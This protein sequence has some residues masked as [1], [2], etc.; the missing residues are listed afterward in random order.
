[1]SELVA[2]LRTL[3]ADA[4]DLRAAADRI[5][6]ADGE[7]ERLRG[8]LGFVARWVSTKP[9]VTAEEVR[10]IIAHH[11]TIKE[12]VDGWGR[13]AISNKAEAGDAT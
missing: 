9:D 7:I 4:A 13:A 1:M 5:E 6:K 2:R 12:I 3:T 10:D 8:V 11:P